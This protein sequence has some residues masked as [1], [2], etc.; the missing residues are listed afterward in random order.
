MF[1]EVKLKLKNA[2]GLTRLIESIME[3]FENMPFKLHHRLNRQLTKL[4]SADKELGDA[5]TST[6]K[7][8]VGDEKFEKL[9]QKNTPINEALNKT[10]LK[11]FE[12]TMDKEMESEI[13]VGL[14]TESFEDLVGNPDLPNEV[15]NA[16]SAIILFLEENSWGDSKEE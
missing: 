15:S 7:G 9:A 12:E 2:V 14:L 13:T 6:I 1:K 16:I 3:G 5:K 10:Q 11:K 8:L 4:A